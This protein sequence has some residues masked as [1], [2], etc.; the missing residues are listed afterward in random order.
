MLYNVPLHK[1]PAYRRHDI[2]DKIWER[3]SPLFP[4]KQGKGGSPSKNDRDFMSAVFWIL[5]TGSP[6]R[7]AVLWYL[8]HSRRSIYG[9]GE[10]IVI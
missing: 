3:L 7:D 5:R 2:S 10:R 8:A 9:F 1:L 6:W 4:Y